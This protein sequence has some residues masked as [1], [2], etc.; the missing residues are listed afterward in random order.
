MQSCRCSTA[1]VA[2]FYPKKHPDNWWLLL[3]CIIAYAACTAAL[4]LFLC[5]FEQDAF[6]FTVAKKVSTVCL[7][8]CC[9]K[10]WLDSRINGYLMVHLLQGLPSLKF[11]SKMPRHSET[12]TLS[13]TVNEDRN[14]QTS[15]LQPMPWIHALLLYIPGLQPKSEPGTRYVQVSCYVHRINH[16]PHVNRA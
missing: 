14:T 12:Y 11:I 2:Q 7:L 16:I 15:L 4:S 6:Y 8:E 9:S 1:L 10:F 3:F 5:R 13:I